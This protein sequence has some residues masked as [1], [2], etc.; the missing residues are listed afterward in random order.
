MKQATEECR[1]G[2]RRMKKAIAGLLIT[3]FVIILNYSL[4]LADEVG[5]DFPHNNLGTHAIGCLSCHYMAAE[6]PPEWATHASTEMDDT[7]FNVLCRSCHNNAI[8]PAMEPHSSRAVHEA[9]YGDNSYPEGSYTGYHNDKT[10]AFGFQGWSVECRTC[11]WPHQQ[12]QVQ[13]YGAASYVYSGT[14]NALTEDSVTRTNAGWTANQYAGYVLIP[15][16][17]EI[18]YQ[19]KITNNTSDTLTV[20]GPIDLNKAAVNNTFAIV[21]GSLTKSTL[22]TSF[23]GNKTVKLFDATGVNSLADNSGGTATDPTPD[24]VCQVCHTETKHWLK[25]G[26]L[27]DHYDGERCTTCHLHSRGFAAGCDGC[28][29]NPPVVNNIRAID[30][31]VVTPSATGSNSAG[32]HSLHATESGYNFSCDTCHYNGMPATD[33]SGNNLIQMGFSVVRGRINQDGA[34]TSYGGRAALTAPYSYEGTNNTTVTNSGSLRCANTYC[35]SNGLK[36]AFAAADQTN[37]SLAWDGS[38]P[39]PQGDNNKCNNCHQYGPAN[40]SHQKHINIGFDDCYLCHYSTTHNG[41]TIADKTKH[42][43]GQFDVG[44]GPGAQFYARNAW[45]PLSFTYTYAPEGGTCSANTCHQ[46]YAYGDPKKWGYKVLSATITLTEDSCGNGTDPTSNVTATIGPGG[47][48]APYECKINWGDD[49][50]LSWDDTP[51]GACTQTKPY[52]IGVYTIQWSVRDS[53]GRILA[54]PNPRTLVRNVCNQSP[55]PNYI[56]GAG[57]D[58]ATY[59][60]RL[61]DKSIDPDYNWGIHSGPGTIRIEWGGYAPGSS[62]IG[63]TEAPINLTN[64]PSNQVF[65]FT[66]NTGAYY[67]VRIKIRDNAMLSTNPNCWFM[68]QCTWNVGKTGASMYGT[69]TTPALSAACVTQNLQQ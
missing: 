48:T 13:T 59:D 58:A 12:M 34:Y 35:H 66:Y 63:I 3:G 52:S 32:A 40:D 42:V 22:P 62:E 23:S 14:V 37:N 69:C 33:V 5:L 24:G 56:F 30:G 64:N 27:A 18:S 45:H 4:V 28:H 50:G 6:T 39:D 54:S 46:Y 17:N 49:P 29:G 41:T 57:P 9:V 25:D 61:T 21:Y 55:T 7:P 2:G 38:S 67:I 44:P 15:N 36:V 60:V 20:E 8:A 53:S 11:H 10:D 16:V 31:L 19:Y 65:S 51:W 47:G 1:R 43:N 68:K 26:T